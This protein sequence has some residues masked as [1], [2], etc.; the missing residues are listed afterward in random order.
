MYVCV[1]NAVTEQ[2]IRQAAG[3]GVAT[4]SELTRRTGCAGCC[5]S[6]AEHAERILLEHRAAAGVTAW[7]QAA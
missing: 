4:L 6:C 7:P 5:G 1:C 2:R 3:D